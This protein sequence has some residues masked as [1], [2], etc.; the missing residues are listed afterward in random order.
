[1]ELSGQLYGIQRDWATNKTIISILVNER[2]SQEMVEEVKGFKL[3]VIL[4]RWREKRS[5][6][7]NA[8]LWHCL[9]EMAKADQSDNWS[10]Y[11]EML[12]KY[13]KYTYICCKPDAVESMKRQWREIEVIGDIETNGRKETQLLCYF[14]SSSY[15]T[16]EFTRLLDGTIKEMVAM[17]LQAPTSQEM[18][19]AL[20]LW[21]KYNK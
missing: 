15:D 12:R 5:K 20:E 8:L 14:G 7:A 3:R 18:K 4:K 16:G 21:E 1:M 19:R 2:I 6:D 17:G 13:G 10:K 11:L 9:G